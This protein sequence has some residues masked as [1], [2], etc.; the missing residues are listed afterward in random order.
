MRQAWGLVKYGQD[1]E[2]NPPESLLKNPYFSK[3]RDVE[4]ILRFLESLNKSTDHAI[5]R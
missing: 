4:L 1:E 3:M 5:K 2:E